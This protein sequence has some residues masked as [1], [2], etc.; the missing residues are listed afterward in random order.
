MD[1]YCVFCEH[2][3]GAGDWNLCCNQY[4]GLCYDDTK[5]C[6]KFKED[7]RSKRA[8]IAAIRMIEKEIK[9]C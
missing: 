1:N 7:Y 6:D 5:A 4:Y 2:Y 9:Q 3:I 8:F